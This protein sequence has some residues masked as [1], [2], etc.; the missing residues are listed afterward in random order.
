MTRAISRDSFSELKQYLGVHLQQGRVILDSDWNESQDIMATLARRLGH[1]AFGDGILNNGFDI[2]ATLPGPWDGPVFNYEQGGLPFLQRF[3]AGAPF[4]ALDAT[5]G[6]QLS[7]A[8]K[9]R[10]SRD[11][12]F[13]GT[14][15]LRVS[16][17]AGQV[18]LTKTLSAPINLSGFQF[19]HFR[20][21]INQSLP[22]SLPGTASFFIEDAST[23]RT[24]I[25]LGG[26]WGAT[27]LWAPG[28]ALA[29]DARFGIVDLD[30]P[31]AFTGVPY[32][33]TLVSVGAPG[34]VTW[35]ASGLPANG[36]S[37]SLPGNTSTARV[38]GTPGSAGPL[39]FTIT[40]T[41]TSGPAVSRTYT[42]RVQ[43]APT[44]PQAYNATKLADD[45]TSFW[46]RTR[47]RVFKPTTGVAADLTQI[48]KYGFE[49]FQQNDKPLVWDFSGL[50]LGNRTQAKDAAN[51]TF[52]IAGP[53]LEQAI[54]SVQRTLFRA[55]EAAAATL[56]PQLA[57]VTSALRRR[58]PRA[59]VG[60]IACTQPREL[61]YHRQADPNDPVLTTP[62]SGEVRKDLVY[63]DVWRESVTYVE[64]PELREVALGGP[65]TATRV[66]VRQRVR[67]AE[68]GELPTNN[69]VGLGTLTTEGNYTDRANR[70]YLVEVDTAGNIGT[71][72]VR[73]SEDNGSTIQRVIDAIP[74]G[75]TTVKVEDAS[76]FQPGDFILIRKEF[77]E[78]THR[79]SAI[80]GNTI[81]LQQATGAQL[82]LLPAGVRQVPGFTTF[83]LEDRPKVQRWNAFKVP[84]TADS[85]DPTLSAAIALSTS[86]VRIRFG[87]RGLK[88][89]DFWTFRARYLAGDD[90]SGINAASRIETVDFEGPQGVV[91]EYVPLAMLIR[92]PD[93]H[94]PDRIN[95]L[96]ELRPHAGHIVV[97]SASFDV[98]AT[99][100]N[101]LPAATIQLGTT[102]TTSTFVCL[103]SGQMVPN[104]AIGSVMR[105]DVK[106]Y[107]NGVADPAKPTADALDTA[108]TTIVCESTDSTNRPVTA[109]AIAG[110]A[111]I[112]SGEAIV[113]AQ[114]FIT[115]LVAPICSYAGQLKIIEIK[116]RLFE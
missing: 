4:D 102:S 111:A 81:T 65:D 56:V 44:F 20:F 68:G 77:G 39:T 59:Y 114:A 26:L 47:A 89:G 41:P 8:G 100:A 42:L 71:A 3:P 37:L 29:L 33:A 105:L 92:A 50:Y 110:G 74:P 63:L 87:G 64:D 69:G 58:G 90:A 91:H 31:P 35:T 73:W 40:A 48:K 98:S 28:A 88:K 27:D 32:V 24:E 15:F 99:L 80:L 67:V 62:L 12:S 109:V 66:R 30:L 85:N 38:T 101:T 72:T 60:G 54:D 115:L 61:L 18:Q 107:G 75:S 94:E 23:N 83:A 17:H 113:A 86:G 45:L 13:D 93:A 78:E 19:A 112:T 76:A 70:L 96:R 14:P 25:R 2:Q 22:F 5:T 1:D 106:F 6:W 21:R 10:T 52:V 79:I 7:A 55:P 9:L 51:N 103:W 82:A 49:V 104:A 84:I 46:D 95:L 36:L 34:A 108:S 43:A 11:R 57:R 116:N 97:H 16:D 53:L